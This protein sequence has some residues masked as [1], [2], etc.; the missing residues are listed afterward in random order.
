MEFYNRKDLEYWRKQA[1]IGTAVIIEIPA[2][3]LLDL[4]IEELSKTHNAKISP[5]EL[6]QWIEENREAFT[7]VAKGEEKK[8]AEAE[9][10]ERE[11]Y[12]SSNGIAA[13]QKPV[14]PVETVPS[15]RDTVSD[16]DTGGAK[17]AESLAMPAGINADQK[18]AWMMEHTEFSE[19][20]I[21]V[22]VEAM[23]QDLPAKY[24]LCFM[25]K[26]Y[27]PAV[28]TQLKDYCMKM[29]QDEQKSSPQQVDS[30]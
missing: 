19:E 16:T 10:L 30:H 3:M 27:S 15:G 12:G 22:I 14:Q 6:T 1:E 8:I 25:K 29:Y 9:K 7:A 2:E 17:N 26:E 23:S 24:L 28:M 20:Q 4:D 5:E 13:E 11:L 18:V 21:V